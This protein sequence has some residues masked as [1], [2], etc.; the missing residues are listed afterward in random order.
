MGLVRLDFHKP[1]E[2][3]DGWRYLQPRRDTKDSIISGEMHVI[4]INKSLN[5]LTISK[6]QSTNPS[7]PRQS[8][9]DSQM[10]FV[11]QVITNLEH[12]KIFYDQSLEENLRNL[13]ILFK[14]KMKNIDQILSTKSPSD[15]DEIVQLLA[16]Y[17]KLCESTNKLKTIRRRDCMYVYA[18]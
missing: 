5:P 12:N 3:R 15:R 1:E 4:W 6:L 18:K 16:S 14:E 17:E 7:S 9:V 2:F 8:E 13:A 11:E 10:F